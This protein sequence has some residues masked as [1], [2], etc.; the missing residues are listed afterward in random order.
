[1]YSDT[2]TQTYPLAVLKPQKEPRRYTLAEYLSREEQSRE[3]HEY[4]DGFITKLPM[5]RGP[6]NII[7]GNIT[8]A[9]NNAFFA[10]GKNYIVMG[11]QQLVYLPK[12]NFS[13]Y[14]DVLTVADTPQYFDKNEVLLI[15]PLIIIEVL[16]KGTS[17][18]DR[19]LKFEE[20]K[21]LNSFEEY[22]IIDP[23]KCRIQT[24]FREE[25]HL[26]RDTS[27][28]DL[29]GSLFLKSV[30]CSIDMSAI[31]RNIHFKKKTKILRG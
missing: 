20:Y 10:K 9:L 3:L 22:I 24:H 17:K 31:Y 14:P 18:Y 21:T 13:L 23:N 28:I 2:Q 15:N 4:Y 26:W 16:S 5:A 8:T 12:L 27:F 30:D 25:P 11:S 6:H 7:V 1:M 19:T 29:N